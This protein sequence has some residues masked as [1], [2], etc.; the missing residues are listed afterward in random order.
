[1]TH[2]ADSLK[3]PP[4]PKLTRAWEKLSKN[5][6]LTIF[7]FAYNVLR[8]FFNADNRNSAGFNANTLPP[9]LWAD[10]MHQMISRSSRSKLIDT[11]EAYIQGLDDIRSYSAEGL[12][13]LTDVERVGV[14][15]SRQ[16]S[17]FTFTRR[18]DNWAI[19]R[20]TVSKASAA[21][22]ADAKEAKATTAPLSVTPAAN[23]G[24]LKTNTLTF[25]TEN[26]DIIVREE[27]DLERPVK[28]EATINDVVCRHHLPMVFA[29]TAA[30]EIKPWKRQTLSSKELKEEIKRRRSEAEEMV[31]A[32]MKSCPECQSM[33]TS[34][35]HLGKLPVKFELSRLH[36]FGE[37]QRDLRLTFNPLPAKLQELANRW[38]TESKGT[39]PAPT[40]T[41]SAEAPKDVKNPGPG[42][43]DRSLEFL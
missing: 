25:S 4:N 32:T 16:D 42:F 6:H 30:P 41:R 10:R 28:F 37:E 21:K 11:D 38:P 14:L 18:P 22:K 36:G 31:R 40:A 12:V 3:V 5:R 26:E 15:R 8:L 29:A 9:R 35:N 2:S 33:F 19:V 1:M 7:K 13:D 24:A 17:I 23:S 43:V 34:A 20:V 39:P 27:I